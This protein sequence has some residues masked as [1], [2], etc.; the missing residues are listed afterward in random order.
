MWRFDA[1]DDL[2]DQLC[3]IIKI[4]LC[5]WT[6]L[7]SIGVFSTSVGYTGGSTDSPSYYK[8]EHCVKCQGL[9]FLKINFMR[10]YFFCLPILLRFFLL[11]FCL[12]LLQSK[13]RG[14]ASV[15]ASF[16]EKYVIP[17]FTFLFALHLFRFVYKIFCSPW[18]ETS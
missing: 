16:I 2:G 12:I 11:S 9:L 4:N 8:Y 7:L 10:N 6:L 3:Y 5:I 15:V 18:S 1:N 13:T 17:F 14:H